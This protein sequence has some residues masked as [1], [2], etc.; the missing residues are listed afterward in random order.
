MKENGKYNKFYTLFNKLPFKG[1][2]DELKEMLVL[3]FTKGRTTSV[4][5]MTPEEYQ[6]CCNRLKEEVE[7]GED[8]RKI[9][10][11]KDNRSAVL[12]QLQLIGVNTADWNK[13]NA[14]CEDKRIAG[15][16]FYKLDIDELKALLPKLRVIRE[17]TEVNRANRL[18][19]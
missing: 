13:V 15:K 18:I 1:D 17:K 4:R 16:S 5:E 11:L 10:V 12:H 8:Y 6:A 19:K 7:G 2:K 9:R 3:E 14:Y